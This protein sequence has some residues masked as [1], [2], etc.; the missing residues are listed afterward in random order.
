M[1]TLAYDLTPLEL[2]REW[3]VTYVLLKSHPL[4]S[5]LATEFAPLRDELLAVIKTEIQLTEQLAEADAIVEF[6][7]EELDAL[8]NAIVNAALT[9]VDGKREHKLFVRL[10][11][12]S[13]PAEVRAHTLGEQLELM[14]NW[15]DVLAQGPTAELQ[16]YAA[17]L[18]PLITKCDNAEVGQKTA[19]EAVQNFTDLG[20]RKQAVDH[21]N[22][23]RKLMFGKI[24]EIV[25]ANANKNLPLDFPERF[26][27]RARRPRP[28]T[29]AS[30]RRIVERL[31]KQLARHQA[32]L[33]ELEAKEQKSR[34]AR[35]AAEAAAME[36]EASELEKQA[37]EM[38]A[39]AAEM[40]SKINK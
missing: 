32:K 36:S 9:A 38:L 16:G 8:F 10:L 39:R 28:P 27:L 22:G 6:S 4:T 20:A 3:G 2:L 19:N 31:E 18:A 25:H 14:K 24:A 37:A 17:T 29:I 13:T 5:R 33:A 15:G 12:T 7:D 21:L 40:K 1:Q 11:G 23:A 35:E 30:E 26:F 34:E